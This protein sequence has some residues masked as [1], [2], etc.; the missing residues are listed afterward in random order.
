MWYRVAA[1]VVLIVQLLFIGFVV[2]G[3]FLAWRWPRVIWVQLPAMVYGRSSSSS[4][5]LAR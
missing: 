3:V 1:D 5:L 2:G 4:A